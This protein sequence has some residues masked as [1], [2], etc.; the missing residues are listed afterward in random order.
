MARSRQAQ[1][2]P[3]P[4]RLSLVNESCRRLRAGQDIG[5]IVTVLRVPLRLVLDLRRANERADEI[6]RRWRCGLFRVLNNWNDQRIMPAEIDAAARREKE[7]SSA[8]IYGQIGGVPADEEAEPPQSE[9]RRR[10]VVQR[11]KRT[12]RACC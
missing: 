11:R 7:A 4:D 5:E 3:R 1:P 8:E 10:M 12:G 6:R 9:R 2:I